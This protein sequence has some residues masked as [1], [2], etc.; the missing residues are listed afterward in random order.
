MLDVSMDTHS[1]A[2]DD[3]SRL[4]ATSDDEPCTVSVPEAS[5]LFAAADLPRTERAIQR[6]CKKG[7]LKCAFVE[8]PFGSKYLIARSS[9][10]RL[11]IQKKQAQKFAPE[12]TSRDLSGPDATGRDMS[13]QSAAA[14]HRHDHR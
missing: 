2:P 4:V 8:T 12:T 14:D 5:E 9:I 1:S 10:D 6:F 11:I 13:R 3:V 7:E